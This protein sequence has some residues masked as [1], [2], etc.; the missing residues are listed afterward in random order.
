MVKPARAK[1]MITGTPWW[2]TAIYVGFCGAAGIGFG[3]ASV[4]A[5]T[6]MWM[7]LLTIVAC[8]VGFLLLSS[9]MPT[10]HMDDR[11]LYI[12]KRRKFA[13][14]SIDQVAGV[15]ETPG[16]W[17]SPP[18]SATIDFSTDTPF[19]RSLYLGV[20]GGIPGMTFPSAVRALRQTVEAR[21]SQSI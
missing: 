3:V 9:S 21:S 8:L 4:I 7:P 2:F 20:T 13:V 19:G 12:S 11:F 18:Y 14:V 17:P 16:S 1:R 5:G 6:V 10:V 15:R